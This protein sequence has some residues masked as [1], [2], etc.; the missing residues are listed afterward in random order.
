MR[1]CVVIAL[2]NKF[3][4]LYGGCV[5]AIE[6]LD[7]YPRSGITKIKTFLCCV[8]LPANLDRVRVVIVGRLA[9]LK[10]CLRVRR[11]PTA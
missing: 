6:Q 4:G 7:G 9:G 10:L 8:G 2:A 1:V 3:A 5:G 11:V